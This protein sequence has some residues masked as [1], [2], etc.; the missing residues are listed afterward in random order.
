MAKNI[1]YLASK[2]QSRQN[3]LKKSEIPFTVLDQNIEELEINHNIT[4]EQNVEKIALSKMNQ[5]NLNN[6]DYKFEDK[7]NIFLLTADTLGQ[8]SNNIIT[9]KPKDY[10]D[11]VLKLKTTRDQINYCAT[12]F[13]LDKR[14]YNL[15]TNSWL[16]LNRIVKIIKSEY[17]FNIPD[18]Y[19][20]YYL[21]NSTALSAS[22]AI[23]IENLGMQFLKYVNG[24]YSSIL[25]LPLFELR[26]ELENLNFIF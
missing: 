17:I 9:G 26:Q 6:L 8:D 14:I 2:S 25:G 20:D 12:A 22:G 19:I 10:T 1:L 5:V 13:V 7:E 18:S 3:L 4:L 21:K 11:A 16:I 24:S 23:T 15:N